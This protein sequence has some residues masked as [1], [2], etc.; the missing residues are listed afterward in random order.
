[1]NDSQAQPHVAMI[2][3][4]DVTADTRVKK[5]AASLAR[6]GFRVTVLGLSPSGS[7]TETSMGRVTIIRLPVDFLLR[8]RRAKRR[9]TLT[10]PSLAYTSKAQYVAAK[11]R[12]KIAEREFV[13]Y[14]GRQRANLAEAQQSA[15]PLLRKL[16]RTRIQSTVKARRMI[17]K[18]RRRVVERR[19]AMWH[20]RAKSPTSHR[21]QGSLRAAFINVAA[22]VPVGAS[23]RRLLPQIN[24]Y[25]LSFGPELDKLEPDVIHAHDIHMI[26]IAERAAVRGRLRGRQ[27]RWIYDAHEYVPGLAR[28]SARV[29]AAY[30]SLEREYIRRADRV[31]TVSEP[32]A[33]QLWRVFDLGRKPAVVLN[34]PLPVVPDRASPSVRQAAGVRENVPLLVYSGGA[35]PTRGVHTIVKALPLMP[36]VH[37]ALVVRS[38]S[39]YVQS[40]RRIAESASCEDRLHIVPFVEPDQVASYLSSASAAVHPLTHYGNHEVA[41]PNK[42][43]EYLH[44]RL[45]VVVSDVRAM[46]QLTQALGIGEVFRAEDPISLAQAAAKTL[47]DPQKYR[48]ALETDSRILLEYSW[49]TQ[50]RV[51]VAVYHDLLGHESPPLEGVHGPVSSLMEIEASRDHDH[52]LA[53]ALGPR[54][55]A[56]QAWEWGK[57]L[58]RCYPGSRTRVFTV[59][60]RSPIMFP[61]D[62]RVPT[63]SWKSLE[64]QLTQV[65][66][67]LDTYT[68]VLLESGSGLFGTLN[69]PSFEGD[70]PSLREHGVKVAVVLHGSEIRDPRRHRELE[71]YS[72]FKDLSTDLAR[73]LLAGVDDLV[74]RLQRFDGPIFVSTIGL[75]DYVPDAVWLPV[76]VDTDLWSP[77]PEP[78][79]RSRPVVVHA[80]SQIALKGSQ[81]I[82]QTVKDMHARGVIEYRQVHNAPAEQMPGI[83]ADA[84]I[85]LDQFALGDYGALAVQ[86]MAS[87]RLVVGHVHDRVR[88]RL[89]VQLP[90]VEATVDSLGDVLVAILED[91]AG[92]ADAARQGPAYV[93]RFHDGTYSGSQLAGFL[94]QRVVSVGQDDAMEPPQPTAE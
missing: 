92:S 78:L 20:G 13:A 59:E 49:P 34:A 3:G 44:A 7:R 87:E 40:L 84:D 38:E 81:L 62:V 23:W 35:D 25:E 88:E 68:H 47:G 54:N 37:L 9:R 5:T 1:M 57:A 27:V 70:L 65:R 63:S 73:R 52:N 61:T 58:E 82:E 69:G 4:N 31:I 85:V 2:V 33:D 42:F 89:P 56:G 66:H 6:H 77:G 8:D 74:P 24:D 64:W 14:A 55:M 90:I 18:A 80:P 39:S 76:V 30:V 43:F 60:K 22:M 51:L 45:P 29:L 16:H 86:A 79:Q 36:G 75:L 83:I 93:R 12:S 11:R 94:D 48:R 28:Y 46:A 21:H 72:P 67:V 17:V 26:G 71:P 41:L 19:E 91:R 15:P 50:E 10:L 32:I 53:V